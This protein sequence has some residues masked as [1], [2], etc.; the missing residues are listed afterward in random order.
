MKEKTINLLESVGVGLRI[1]S[2]SVLSIMGKITPL[3]AFWIANTLSAMILTY[4]ATER[5]N[6]SYIV[7]N[8]F[9]IIVGLVGIYN[10]LK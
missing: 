4:C 2:F 5:K 6:K 9:W 1:L 8:T 3:L 10:S 7:L